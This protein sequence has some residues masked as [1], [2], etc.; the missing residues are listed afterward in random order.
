M[1]SLRLRWP[2]SASLSARE[3]FDD[4]SPSS[5]IRTSSTGICRLEAHVI[6]RRVARHAQDPCGEQD[7][8]LLVLLNLAHQLRED[9]VGDVLGV[10]A[11]ADDALNEPRTSSA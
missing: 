8:P 11:V 7:L 10:M 4:P 5:L 2:A 3:S 1:A 6:E 9:V